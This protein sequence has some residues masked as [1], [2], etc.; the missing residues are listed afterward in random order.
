MILQQKK[1]GLIDLILIPIQCA[2]VAATIGFIMSLIKNGAPILQV[3]VTAKFID[4]AI[5]VVQGQTDIATVLPYLLAV[6]ILVGVD[7]IF[8]P[9]QLAGLPM[10]WIQTKIA[11]KF[12]SAIT[13]KKAKLQYSSVEN[14]ETWDLVERISDKP[15][16]KLKDAFEIFISLITI[17]IKVVG[18]I[19]I[20]ASQVWWAAVILFITTIPI[21][22][23]SVK[24]GKAQYQSVRDT[25]KLKR[26]Y[27]YLSE[28]LTGREA[29]NERAVFEYGTKLN[30]TWHEH[31]ETARKI[32][33]K[34]RL[35]WYIRETS[36]GLITSLFTIIVTIVLLKPTVDGL[37]TIGMFMSLTNSFRS[38]AFIASWQLNFSIRKLVGSIE[39]MNDLT[40]FC[41][42]QQSEDATVK[43]SPAPLTFDSIVFD[44][45]R[46]SYPGANSEILKG[47]HFTIESGKHYAFV[48]ANGAGKTTI[49]KLI[50]GLY[51]GYSGNILVN[52]KRLT[53]Y[54]EAE[55]K[56]LSAVVY[57]DFA[58]YQITIK[59][60]IALG[61]VNALNNDD[62]IHSAITTVGLEQAIYNLPHNINSYLGKLNQDGVDLSGGQWQRLAMARAIVNPAPLLI[63]DEP[64]AA[65]DPV[66]ES[67]IYEE[68]EK[69]SANRTTIFIS[70]RLGSTKL[71]DK[72]FV[73]DD[74]TIAEEGTHDE[75]IA[76]NQIY[77]TMYE[78]QRGWYQ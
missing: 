59:D 71:A 38:L 28:I 31:Y 20:L 26:N 32:Q 8:S 41:A 75:L 54:S 7:W 4:L 16:E 13:E 25:S 74:G 60:N 58:R 76:R 24:S 19:F 52:G 65:L 5:S 37:L 72:I 70:H 48:G 39:M 77:A 45:V 29:V 3:L 10:V 62:L 56:S 42:L 36:G 35:K 18:L 9:W 6:V 44:N 34:T 69:L 66:S 33:L 2:P 14:S 23:M 49:T 43:P 78:S 30:E 53:D 64:T 21:F 11:E 27:K 68:F 57:Q 12:R 46:F 63:L 67:K 61:N 55:I 73:I 22:L 50:T 1:Y 17:I 51:N 15:E 40:V 47:I